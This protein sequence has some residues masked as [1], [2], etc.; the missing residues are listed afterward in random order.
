MGNIILNFVGHISYDTILTH[1]YTVMPC[2][3]H[4]L[5]YLRT[6]KKEC[7][8][9]RYLHAFYRHQDKLDFVTKMSDDAVYVP[10][11]RR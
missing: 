2:V 3:L 10:Y 7:T 9:H 11:T 8:L 5:V 6:K 4:C 1:V